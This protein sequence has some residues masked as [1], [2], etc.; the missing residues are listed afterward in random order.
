[1]TSCHINV[2]TNINTYINVPIT[3]TYT[4]MRDQLYTDEITYDSCVRAS[5]RFMAISPRSARGGGA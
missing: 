4:P 1:M 5:G 2:C 3:H